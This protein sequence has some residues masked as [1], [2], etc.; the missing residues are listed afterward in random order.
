M[1]K[2]KVRT[3]GSL[4]LL[5]GVILATAMLCLSGAA[6]AALTGDTTSP[7][8][9]SDK[10][11]YAPGSTVTLDGGNWVAGDTVH[12]FVDDSSNH[13]WQHSADVT[14]DAGGGI[15]YV[16]TLPTTFVSDY[17]V[18]ATD[19]ATGD[20]ATT[21]FTDADLFIQ[22]TDGSAPST[23]ATQGNQRTYKSVIIGGGNGCATPVTW[24]ATNATVT[25]TSAAVGGTVTVTYNTVGTATV[26]VT[27]AHSTGSG[28]CLGTLTV[29]V[30]APPDTTPPS[31]AITAPA[32][33]SSTTSSSITVSGTASDANGIQ[34]VKVNGVTATGTTT[35][36]LSGVALACGSNTITAVATDNSTAHNTNS[37]SI[38]VTR[39]CD[40]TPP[41]ITKS[42]T[43]TAGSNGWYTSN[44]SV[45]WSV[46]DPDSAVVIDSGCG[47]QSFTS[48]TA[49]ATSSCSAHSSGG[50]ASDS[51]TL[52]I[53]KEAPTVTVAASRVPDHNGWYN[54]AVTFSA[55]SSNEGP[56]GAGSCDSSTTYSGPDT[57][58]D[59][60]TLNCSDG[61]GNSGAGTLA[62]KYDNTNPSVNVVLARVAD[63]SGWYNHPV[64][65]SISGSDQTSQIASCDSG[66]TYSGPDDAA[67]G[68]SGS[69][70]DNAGNIGNA[71]QT[72]KY[73]GTAPTVTVAAAR[74]A[75]HNGWYNHAVSFSASSSNEGPSGAGS[76]DA[77][78]NYSGPEG[79]SLSVS[80]SC[81][82]GAGNSASGSK[83]FDYDDTAPTASVVAAR[84]SDHNGWYNHAV[85]FSASGSDYGASGPAGCDAAMTYSG[86]DDG[87]ASVTLGCSDGAGN[88]GTDT[89]H[90]M[91]DATNPTINASRS[92]AA[93]G[94]GWNKASVVVN[95][96]CNDG[97][98][99]VASCGPDET[100]STE[101]ANQSSSGTGVDNAGN[102]ASTT[103]SNINIDKTNPSVSL[104]GGPA[105]GGSYYFGS[106]PAA[107]TCTA[108][109]ALSGVD[110]SCSVSGYSTALGSHTVSASAND[111]AG[112]SNSDSHTYNVNPWTLRGFYAPV[113][114]GSSVVNTVKGG[115]TVP[116]KFEIFA[117]S[118]ELTDT[119]DVTSL[120]AKLVPCT[121][122]GGDALDEIE[123]LATGGTSLRYDTTAGQFIYNWKT[124]TGAGKCYVVTMTTDDG[125]SLSAQFKT[126]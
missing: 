45:V 91:Y 122:F 47:T 70:S 105:Q 99:G 44:V 3:C 98:S 35:W 57:V 42:I 82:D 96:T 112:N 13:T 87:S 59:S 101:G 39:N 67:A 79:A 38:S 102:S 126:K 71:S 2:S 1:A 12:I 8:I 27:S 100:L 30:G 16:F 106:V 21:S 86:P 14:V 88:R 23:T 19:A 32:N 40:T 11:D 20:T 83:P 15:H 54:A 65:Y 72:I 68:L 52:K 81:S 117:G 55:S 118:N 116:L 110:G 66:G 115:S 119:A 43:G 77:A 123:V 109:D 10:A 124:P 85:G 94:F 111:K 25:P 7:W 92:P 76:C 22:N 36:S 60:V 113:D 9:Q 108:S 64:A 89:K 51:V 104:V 53:D 74:V 121:N 120:A 84:D 125:S 33:N 17:S 26:S 49:S 61:A 95:Y 73:D 24:S 31:V 37:D 90:F 6:S 103:V 97:T 48:S 28:N 4:S 5:L 75:D 34:S 78:I 50:S 46:S 93:N 80:L 18:A 56:S 41:L 69:C 63:H 58:S 62:F 107:P 114:M 29:S